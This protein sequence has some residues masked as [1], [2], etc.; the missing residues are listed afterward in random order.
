M[1]TSLTDQERRVAMGIDSLLSGKVRGVGG[2]S[3]GRVQGMGLDQH[4][5]V[6][7]TDQTAVGPDT[8]PP[9]HEIAGQRVE[10]LGDLDV[11]IPGDFGT[12]PQRHVVG[13]RRCRQQG[14]TLYGFEVFPRKPLS[15]SVTP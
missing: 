5:A 13:L 8:Q 9:A 10:C 14:R 3:A 1:L 7:E 11:L 15:S 4:A 12:A 2:P 6:I